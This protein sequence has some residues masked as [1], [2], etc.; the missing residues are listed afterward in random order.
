LLLLSTLAV[1]KTTKSVHKQASTAVKS[2]AKH[3][4]S[5]HARH[6]RYSRRSR[7][8]AWKYRGQ[9]KPDSE[10][11][12][13]IQQALIRG[14]YLQGQPSGIWDQRTREAMARFQQDHGWQTKMVPDARA[15][16]QLGLGPSHDGLINPET[17]MTSGPIVGGSGADRDLPSSGAPFRQ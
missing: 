14:N 11:T 7:R 3:V 13:A 16:I 1:A 10:R 2:S 15:L 6:S 9:Q 12:R 8:M 17:A 5:R 4:A